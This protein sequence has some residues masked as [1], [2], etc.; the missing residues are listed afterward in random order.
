MNPQKQMA[1]AGH[2]QIATAMKYVQIAQADK[3]PEVQGIPD[4]QGIPEVQ[5]IPDVKPAQL[6]A[7]G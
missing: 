5:G 4:V 3:R 7:V 6:K 2:R 1:L